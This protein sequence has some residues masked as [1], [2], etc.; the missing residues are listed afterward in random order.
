MFSTNLFANNDVVVGELSV[1]SEK[2]YV[3]RVISR[4]SGYH[5]VYLESGLPDLGCTLTDR[6][7]ILNTDNGSESMLS[8][9]TMATIHSKPVRINVIGCESID[10]N[11]PS[12]TAPKAVTVKLF[13]H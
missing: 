9:A 10:A 6:A 2:S 11:Q 4:E 7:I 5:A 3:H 13:R 8:L 1:V 12:I